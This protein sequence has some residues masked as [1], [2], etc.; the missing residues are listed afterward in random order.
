[1]NC[2]RFTQDFKKSLLEQLLNEAATPLGP[3]RCYNISSDQLYTWKRQYA[4]GKLN[5]EPSREAKL[6]SK[7]RELERLGGKPFVEN[8]FLK[9]ITNQPQTSREKRGFITQN[10][11]LFKSVQRG[12][13]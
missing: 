1:M 3:C 13:N 4:Q 9:S 6:A 11:T 10:R 2:R 5:G 7:V 8:E 12:T